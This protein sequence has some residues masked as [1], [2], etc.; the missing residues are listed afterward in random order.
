LPCPIVNTND[1]ISTNLA[2]LGHCILDFAHTPLQALILAVDALLSE[3]LI[4]AHWPDALMFDV[5]GLAVLHRRA[6]GKQW[7]AETSEDTWAKSGPAPSCW[8]VDHVYLGDELR[9]FA[10]GTWLNVGHVCRLV[11]EP[12]QL[13]QH[14]EADSWFPSPRSIA[15]EH[16]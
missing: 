2:D 10:L 15:A 16:D 7:A 8:V 6:E 12:Q 13:A 3:T 14:P 9:V 11:A 5:V 4:E 1:A